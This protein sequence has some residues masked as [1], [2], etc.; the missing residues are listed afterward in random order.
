MQ[1]FNKLVRDK[2]PDIIKEQG[3]TPHTRILSD[4]QYLLELDRKLTEELEEISKA[5]RWKL[6][7][8][9]EVIDAICIARSYSIEQLQRIKKEK[10]STNGGFSGKV[11]LISKE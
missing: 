8:I 1:K 2:I 7:D 11:F 6:A 10:R 4:G 5:R 3:F 9:L